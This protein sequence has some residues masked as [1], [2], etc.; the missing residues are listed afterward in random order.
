MTNNA[1]NKKICGNERRFSRFKQ[2]L[3][4]LS[5]AAFTL[6]AG[7][8]AVQAQGTIV[9]PPITINV[10][11]AAYAK[12]K[13]A[14]QSDIRN[15][16][17]SDS[18]VATAREWGTN[19]IQINAKRP[20]ATII[21]FLDKNTR[22]NYQITVTVKQRPNPQPAPVNPNPNN[23]GG[24]NNGG[25]NNG[26][27]KG[28]ANTKPVT[29]REIKDTEPV[30]EPV[31]VKFPDGGYKKVF[32]NKDKEV[33]QVEEY[34]AQ[35]KPTTT[36]YIRK[37]Y[38][39]GKE[40]EV[41]IATHEVGAAGDATL[42]KSDVITYDPTGKV[43]KTETYT[44]Y[45]DED[46]PATT[47]I[48]TENGKTT[49]YKWDETAKQ[50]KPSK[51]EKKE[52]KITDVI[53]ACLVGTWRS[54]SFSVAGSQRNG[55]QGIILEIKKDGKISINY[56]EMK[57]DIENLPN[58]VSTSQG[59]RGTAKGHISVDKQG[60]VKILSVEE[61]DITR[62]MNGKT[63]NKLSGLGPASLGKPPLSSYTCDEKT[64]K[65]Q[66]FAT[67]FTFKKVE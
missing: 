38:S 66:A 6:G 29:I 10:D 33:V 67:D 52:N 43:V 64:L 47:K 24:G 25:N 2:R 30:G 28:G 11:D 3:A 8:S 39:N 19:E 5:L 53:D 60:I 34:D 15:I 13:S 32:K 22:T 51:E 49:I 44:D 14:S 20:G 56:N 16:T 55:G 35:D 23:P 31:I 63:M 7:I 21:R 54:E 62:V 48:V 4:L 40:A 65:F 41:E 46:S 37:V 57:D 45:E 61:S 26:A 9:L 18:N 27:I 50:Y 12:T 36:K 1:A 59:W 58:G 42:K 17:S